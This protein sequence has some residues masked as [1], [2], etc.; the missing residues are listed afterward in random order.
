MFLVSG[1]WLL[2]LLDYLRLSSNGAFRK[3]L[4]ETLMMCS[5]RGAVTAESVDYGGILTLTGHGPLILKQ[6]APKHLLGVYLLRTSS[7][8]NI[9]L[10]RRTFEGLKGMPGFCYSVQVT[11]LLGAQITLVNR[12]HKALTD[13]SNTT[14]IYSSSDMLV[15]YKTVQT[16][17]GSRQKTLIAIF[18]CYVVEIN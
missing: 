15:A 7:R 11:C 12:Q 9:K 13:Y 4:L 5:R 16:S 18:D 2:F 10:L 14:V 1:F 6:I 3:R 17:K 8:P